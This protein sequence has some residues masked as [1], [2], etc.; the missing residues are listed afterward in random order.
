M[1]LVVLLPFA[2][3]GVSIKEV[4]YLGA[5]SISTF[6]DAKDVNLMANIDVVTPQVQRQLI[7]SHSVLVGYAPVWP[8]SAAP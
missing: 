2:G 4:E 8:V 1:S 7:G 5:A 6:T 3:F